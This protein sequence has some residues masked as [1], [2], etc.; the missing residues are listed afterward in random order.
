MEQLEQ[1]QPQPKQ[2]KYVNALWGGVF[3]GAVTGIPLLNLVNCACCSGII[4][5][6]MLTIYLYRSSLKGKQTVSLAE[7]ATLGLVAGLIGALIG[8]VLNSVF[9]AMTRDIAEL[10]SEHFQ[11]FDYSSFLEEF[12]TAAVA[13]GSFLLYILGNFVVNCIFGVVGGIIGAAVFGKA[14]MV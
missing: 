5:G 14:K 9:G 1:L 4:A 13:K 3:I 8:G 7:G 10:V 11:E 12:S 6:G 2:N